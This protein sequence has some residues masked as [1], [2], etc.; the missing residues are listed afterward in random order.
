MTIRL[1][2]LKWFICLR[3][4]LKWT[5]PDYLRS[6]K[7]FHRLYARIIYAIR[8]KNVFLYGSISLLLQSYIRIAHMCIFTFFVVLSHACINQMHI[9]CI[10]VRIWFHNIF[11]LIC[12][13][14]QEQKFLFDV[15]SSVYHTPKWAHM[16]S[17]WHWLYQNDNK[18]WQ[19]GTNSH[20]HP[21]TPTERSFDRLYERCS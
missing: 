17:K 1:L 9:R 19:I 14:S 5:G 10:Y 6:R 15:L 20:I 11:C 2:E 21:L 18:I 12:L 4:K 16:H 7:I 8:F 3:L 13:F